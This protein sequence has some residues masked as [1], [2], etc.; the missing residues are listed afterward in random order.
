MHRLQKLFCSFATAAVG[1]WALHMYGKNA[2]SSACLQNLLAATHVVIV[3]AMCDLKK[4]VMYTCGKIKCK[5]EVTKETPFLRDPSYKAQFCVTAYVS[6][7][8][9]INL[10]LRLQD[11]VM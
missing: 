1:R 6:T 3:S 2:I 8:N 7:K 10:T 4:L 11:K 5:Q 9:Y